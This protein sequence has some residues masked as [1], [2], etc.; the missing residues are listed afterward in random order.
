MLADAL[1]L[2]KVLHD[3]GLSEEQILAANPLAPY[4]HY[5]WTFITTEKMTRTIIRSLVAEQ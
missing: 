2:V 5:S 4:E 3:E 1:A